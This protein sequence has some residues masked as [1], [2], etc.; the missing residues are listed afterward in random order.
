[1]HWT[2]RDFLTGSSILAAGVL[3][4]PSVSTGQTQTPGQGPPA[5][6]PVEFR[7]LRGNV[8]IFVGQGGTIGWLISPD[9]VAVVD[10]QM[11]P[12]AKLCLEGLNARS[13]NRP[14]ECLFN[15]HHHGDHTSGNGVFRPV[16]R[17][18]VAHARVPELQKAAARPG[19]E[20]DQ[21]YA[22]TTF[23]DRWTVRI[24]SEIVTA[25]YA[26]PAHTGGDSIIT[27]EQANVVHVGDLVFNRRIPALDRPGG[28]RIAAWISVLEKIVRDFP[29]DASYIFGHA[30]PGVTV[31]GTKDDLLFQRDF[32]SALLD[33]VRAGIKGGRSRDQIVNTAVELKGFPD[34]GPLTDRVLAA[35][36]EELTQG[37]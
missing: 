2:R 20:A 10:A 34:H 24:G 25:V 11:P 17:K 15:T 13:G 7:S 23:S 37:A 8:G 19:T 12:T 14:I 9:G 32:L 4:R 33:H 26:G 16:A 35:A 1:M 6:Q 29:A 27:F 36:Y 30:R 18:I 31:T 5:S 28:C 3:G 22:D 21:V